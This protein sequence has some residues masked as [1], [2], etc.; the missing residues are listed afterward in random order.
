MCGMKACSNMTKPCKFCG[1]GPG[2]DLLIGDFNSGTDSTTHNDLL[3]LRKAKNP[4]TQDSKSDSEVVLQLDGCAV[5]VVRQLPY[6][7]FHLTIINVGTKVLLQVIDMLDVGPKASLNKSMQSFKK[8]HAFPKGWA[9]NRLPPNLNTTADGKSLK[10]SNAQQVKSL[11]QVFPLILKGNP[12]VLD[13]L[14]GKWVR[15]LTKRAEN[16]LDKDAV[17]IAILDVIEKIAFLLKLVFEAE[18][19][20]GERRRFRVKIADAAK[21]VRA[22]VFHLWGCG[23]LNKEEADVT[24]QRPATL[25]NIGI[26][27]GL[28]F[29]VELCV[30]FAVLSGFRHC[31]VRLTSCDM[32]CAAIPV[33]HGLV[34]LADFLDAYGA[35]CNQRYS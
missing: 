17:E 26:V 24:P 20:W 11:L 27:V 12:I 18:I 7:V 35:I 32:S 3:K 28:Q 21:H 5:D 8:S 19:P 2:E 16:P 22:A 33:M 14:R 23:G 10:D 1:C 13:S 15:W 30:G 29:C 34:H 4:A 9:K 6:E 31:V 25:H